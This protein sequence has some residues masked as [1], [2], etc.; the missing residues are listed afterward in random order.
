[1]KAWQ[2]S[3]LVRVLTWHGLATLVVAVLAAASV[4]WLLES[5]SARLQHQTLDAYAKTI[6][7]GLLLIDGQWQLDA[8]SRLSVRGGG[9][10]FA[11]GVA[12]ADGL[13][14][15][16]GLPAAAISMSE[17]M[18]DEP[19][20][21]QR[22][23]GS[24]QFVGVFWPSP[25]VPG[26]AIIVIQNLDDPGVFFDDVN[27]RVAIVAGLAIAALLVLLMLVDVIIVKRSLAPVIRA[28]QE[29]STVRS[30]DLN[31]RIAT[32]GVPIE[33]MPLVEG[34]NR[35]FD[36]LSS[37]YSSQR[38]FHA[39]AA[40]ALRTPL[41][42]LQLRADEIADPSL[43]SSMTS[44]IRDLR[45]IVDGLLSLA[46][47]DNAQL[48]DPVQVDLSLLAS[49][50]VSEIAPLA[51]AKGKVISVDAPAPF[52]AMT[53]AENVKRALDAILENAVIHTPHGTSIVV[54][55]GPGEI[56]VSDDGPGIQDEIAKQIFRRFQRGDTLEEGCGLGLAIAE[57]LM[58]SANGELIYETRTS[59]GSCFRLRFSFLAI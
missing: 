12:D 7:E 36:R 55:V 4:S 47:I 50:R 11:F 32:S 17:V 26:R 59:G 9:S 43:R 24:D 10:S 30:Y 5:T 15:I 14:P 48:S 46:E 20:Y 37:A 29:I 35:A 31:T 3:M 44:Q 40:H 45:R 56:T 6:D 16:D 53:I 23:V 42:V 54:S 25:N 49:D 1:M 41:A 51:L 27:T 19:E 38:D 52:F 34:A 33:V 13:R 2:Q 39:D 8:E 18:I 28:S 58:K 57:R 21:F 22:L